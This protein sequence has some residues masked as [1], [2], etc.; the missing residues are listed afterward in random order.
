M[1]NG[2]STKISLINFLKIKL[3]LYSWTATYSDLQT[4]LKYISD[5]FQINGNKSFPILWRISSLLC[6]R[7]LFDHHPVFTSGQRLT[8]IT[9][10]TVV[11]RREDDDHR[12]T[13]SRKKC[14]N[15]GKSMSRLRSNNFGTFLTRQDQ[16]KINYVKWNSSYRT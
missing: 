12:P 3:P 11:Y 5:L 14:V 4:V 16:G 10:K 6:R 7:H 13:A 8:F 9:C 15:I 2:K 1:N